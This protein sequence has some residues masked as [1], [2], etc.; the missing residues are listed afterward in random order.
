MKVRNR[1]S[2]RV[3]IANVSVTTASSVQL[4]QN[5]CKA[6]SF[7]VALANPPFNVLGHGTLAPSRLKAAA[8][9]M[10]ED[11]LNIWARFLAR[12]TRPG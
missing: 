6:N 12:M 1:L 8:H 2:E 9:A 4:E 7:D 3:S 11:D 10:H 5:G